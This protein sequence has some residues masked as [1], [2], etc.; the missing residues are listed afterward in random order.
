[1][2]Q[3]VE[4][5]AAAAAGFLHPETLQTFYAMW[6]AAI[7]WHPLSFNNLTKKCNDNFMKEERILISPMSKTPNP[8]NSCSLNTYLLQ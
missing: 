2:M 5:P 3:K 4:M 7:S 1:M 6:Q 8:N